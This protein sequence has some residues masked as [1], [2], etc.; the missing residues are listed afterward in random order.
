LKKESREADD[1]CEENEDEE[2]KR[3]EKGS[4]RGVT[5]RRVAA[6]GPMEE[7]WARVDGR[8]DDVK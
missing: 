7:V 1:E 5:D 3:G 8:G 6:D 2:E 4:E